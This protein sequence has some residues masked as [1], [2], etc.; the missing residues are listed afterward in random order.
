METTLNINLRTVEGGCTY[1]QI[2]STETFENLIKYMDDKLGQ[3]YDVTNVVYLGFKYDMN[4][5]CSTKLQDA[6]VKN[7]SSV[8]LIMKEKITWKKM[9]IEKK[10]EKII[11]IVDS[12]VQDV[13]PQQ[14]KQLA[15]Q[16]NVSIS[17]FP[18]MSQDNSV[19]EIDAMNVMQILEMVNNFDIDKVVQYYKAN[20]RNVSAT[21]NAL[22]DST[23]S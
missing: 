1:V 4:T 6:S 5:Y 22:L 2:P 14:T 19:S 8:Y 9:H 23:S 3:Q 13:A 11:A 16:N 7:N 17:Q 18:V 20:G 21:V 10:P 15:P 12:F